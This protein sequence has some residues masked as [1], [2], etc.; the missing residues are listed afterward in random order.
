MELWIG[1]EI[2]LGSLNRRSF[3]AIRNDIEERF[4]AYLKEI[5]YTND[6]IDEL[7]QIIVIRD[8]EFRGTEGGEKIQKNEVKKEYGRSPRI[9]YQAFVNADENQRKVLIYETILESLRQLKEDK[10]IKNLEPLE[11]YVK[12][13]IEALKA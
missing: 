13:E 11:A 1:G 12:K 4:N 2:G 5:G 10:K 8:D 7:W 9:D 3:R 6:Q